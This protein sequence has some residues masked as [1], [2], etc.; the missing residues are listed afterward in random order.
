MTNA[1][2]NGDIPDGDRSKHPD[3][4]TRPWLPNQ[5]IEMS[6][7]QLGLVISNTKLP[8]FIRAVAMHLVTA[9]YFNI[10]Y[11]FK[12]LKDTDV[13]YLCA[14][15]DQAEAE[16]QSK[17]MNCPTTQQLILLAFL[18]GRAEGE[19]ETSP[20]YIASALPN[21]K[22][23][24]LIE[25]KAREGSL[26]VLYNNYSLTDVNKIVILNK[27]IQQLGRIFNEDENGD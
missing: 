23:L 24:I 22:T 7:I 21:L 15:L 4:T 18:L 11:F 17:L 9:Q 13:K 1:V 19:T 6:C 16:Q 12:S 2:E 20:E 8:P 26:K 3:F 10:G 14:M 5:L 27:T 25:K